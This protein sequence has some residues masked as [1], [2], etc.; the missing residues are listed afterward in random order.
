MLSLLALIPR[1][2]L[3]AVAVLFAV[4][5]GAQSVRLHLAQ[6]DAAGLRAELAAERQSLAEAGRAAEA[7]A[8]SE[9]SRRAAAIAK[10]AADARMQTRAAVAAADDLRGELGRLRERAQAL[11][12][13]SGASC[14]ASTASGSPPVDAPAAVLADML[15]RVAGAAGDLAAEA[16]ARGRAG[17][18]CQRAYSAVTGTE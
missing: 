3:L 8:R 17:D 7:A 1:P 6:H 5:A 12:G 10:V 16:D 14:S 15:G 2:V 13:D 9:E 4:L 11:V 18:A